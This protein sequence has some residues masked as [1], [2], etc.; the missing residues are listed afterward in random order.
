MKINERW[1]IVPDARNYN[2]V[3]EETRIGINPK[4]KQPS[5]TVNKTFHASVR[6]CAHKIAQTYTLEALQKKQLDEVIAT[7]E[8]FA[9]ALGVELVEAMAEHDAKEEG[10]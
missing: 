4:T 9:E 2:F 10:V 7:I 1:T 8:A 5:S 6:Q 3:L